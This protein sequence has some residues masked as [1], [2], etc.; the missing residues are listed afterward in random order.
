MATCNSCKQKWRKFSGRM[1]ADICKI[2]GKTPP[3]VICKQ[4]EPRFV[5]RLPDRKKM[6]VELL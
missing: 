4:Y 3:M 6:G 1:W 5:D 2:T